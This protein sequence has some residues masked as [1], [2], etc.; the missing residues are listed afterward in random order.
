MFASFTLILTLSALF[1]YI[2][3]KLIKLP[4]TIGQM[5]LAL[6][7]AMAL[8]GIE[9]LSAGTYSYFCQAVLDID[10]KFILLDVMLSFLL[11]AGAL[12]VPINEL[13]KQ[14]NSVILFATLGVLIST[15]IVGGLLYLAAQLVGLELPL[16]YALLFGALIS[17][18]DPIAVLA[19]LKEAKVQQSME[20]TIEGESLFND[21]I[22]VVIFTAILSIATAMEGTEVGAESILE[23]LAVEA[24][25]G[26]VYG[27]VIG[28]LGWQ[29]IR[30][31][32][33]DPRICVQLTLAVA[34][35]GY[36]L[37]MILGVSG[38]LAMV[39]AGLY[40]GNHVT[41][42]RFAEGARQL[43][44]D[45]WYVI[46][47]ILNGVLFV[48]IGLVI[49]TLDNQTTYFILGG[50]AILIVLL[51]RFASVF[52]PYSLLHRRDSHLL[53]KV[54]IFTWGGLRGGISVALALSISGT[55]AIPD[56][57]LFIT[58]AVVI[59]SIL[60]QGLTLKS[61]VRRVQPPPRTTEPQDQPLRIIS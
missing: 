56:L 4:S 60:V 38:P 55:G 21:G 36:S 29:L 41:S 30:S 18:T 27:L 8:I 50:L 33:D 32:D 17:P 12:H 31:I 47:E 24:L 25:G 51:A 3:H 61:F 5:L 48:L 2:N 11:F 19:I 14:T 7:L 22:G 45:F 13:R 52:L 58:Y 37:A 39:V 57:L 23:L 46:D 26:L 34:M 53:G 42:D 35:G 1:T 44:F 40:I 49:F 28:W 20:L 10:F 15:A 9:Q 43:I 59:F 54:G 6:L 16:I